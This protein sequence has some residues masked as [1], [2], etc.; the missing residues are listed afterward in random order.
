MKNFSKNPYFLIHPAIFYLQ[1]TRKHQVPEQELQTEG[2]LNL[3]LLQIHKQ[4]LLKE[5]I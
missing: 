2:L 5:K 3:Y 4:A 1:S